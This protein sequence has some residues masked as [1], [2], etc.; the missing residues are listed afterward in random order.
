M[1]RKDLRLRVERLLQDA[2]NRRWED[3]EINGY[4][5]NAQLEFCRL[6]KIPRTSTSQVLVTVATRR[7]SCTSSISSKTATI[8]LDG[9]ETHTLA[10][11]DSALLSGSDNSNINGGHIVTSVPN[12]QSFTFLLDQAGS[13]SG[14]GITMVE[15]GPVFTKASTVLE[16]NSVSVDGR[17][18]S[19]HTE[20]KMNNASNRNIG[21]TYYLSTTLGATPAPFFDVGS[22]YNV[23]K[24]R[25]LEGQPEAAVFSER[26]ASTFRVFPLPSKEEH[27]YVDKDASTKVSKTILVDGVEKP[28]SLSTDSSTPIIPEYYHE[29]LIYGSL[30]RAYLKESQMRNIDKANSF[31][32]KFMELATEALR[33]EGLNSMSIGRGRNLGSHMVWR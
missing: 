32:Y 12:D 17:E 6:A 14:T 4:L 31:R 25:E 23:P 29:A 18:L 8:T 28:V 1:T 15:T 7:T 27:V 26:S 20:S 16:M 33:N 22:Y 5:D 11:N 9:S 13:G 21:S 24:W 2:D 30:E 3:A 19:L 10:V